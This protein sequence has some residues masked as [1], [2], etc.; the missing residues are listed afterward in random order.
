MGICRAVQKK[1]LSIFNRVIPT[2]TEG[3]QGVTKA[4]P[5]FMF[6]EMTETNPKS[7]YLEHQKRE[8]V[9]VSKIQ[10]LLS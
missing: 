7:D 10:K 4:M 9:W 6:V 2:T 5:K 8:I 3:V 1:V